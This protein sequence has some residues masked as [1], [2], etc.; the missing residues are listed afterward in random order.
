MSGSG[1]G[2]SNTISL[3]AVPQCITRPADA[4]RPNGSPQHICRGDC[5]FES[6]K[7]LTADLVERSGKD[8]QSVLDLFF[9]HN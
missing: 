7:Q 2:A 5:L 6:S 3:A 4:Q 9:R 8:A 1:G